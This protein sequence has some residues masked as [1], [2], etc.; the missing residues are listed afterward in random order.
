MSDRIKV[1]KY[2][3]EATKDEQKYTCVIKQTPLYDSLMDASEEASEDGEEPSGK[4]FLEA[5]DLLEKYGYGPSTNSGEP[6]TKG[7]KRGVRRFSQKLAG[8]EK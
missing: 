1:A 7:R 2:L 4:F 5:I 6:V 8:K 3:L